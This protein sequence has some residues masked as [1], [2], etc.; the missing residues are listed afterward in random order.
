MNMNKQQRLVGTALALS[1]L[2]ACS[3][4]PDQ[5]AGGSLEQSIVDGTPT[6][7]PA[8]AAVGGIIFKLAPAKIQ[9]FSCSGTLIAPQVFLTARHCVEGGPGWHFLPFPGFNNFVAF[10]ASVGKPEQKVKIKAYVTAPPSPAHPGLLGDGG[11]DVAVLYLDQ[12]PKNIVPAKL[13]R[14]DASMVSGQFT[15]AGYGQTEQFIS[16]NK[17]VGGV[18][19]RAL[20]GDWYP[21][22][23]NDD[24]DAFDTWYWTD[25]SLAT[26]SAA[27]EALWW[28]P[29]T[30]EL[31]PGYELLAGGL[32]GDS[33]SCWGDSGGPIFRGTTA[34]DLTVYGVSFAGEGSI[35]RN[36]GLGGAYAVLNDEM[37]AFVQDAVAAAPSVLGQH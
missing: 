30:Y 15:I 13:G 8:L 10:G 23:F 29:G 32:P 27:E 22:L 21:L 9:E 12:A 37:L 34:A 24:Y 26:P 11:R 25:A 28:T 1:L 14:F 3:A 5:D 4:A 17:L 2:A 18:T 35:A 6:N 19:G 36:C 20:S 7:D 31:E 33:L 16:G